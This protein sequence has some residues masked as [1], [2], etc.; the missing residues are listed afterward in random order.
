MLEHEGPA[1][2]G[3]DE[4]DPV[5]TGEHGSKVILAVLAVGFEDGLLAVVLFE[6]VG[7]NL[8][9]AVYDAPLE[10]AVLRY[11]N[12]WRYLAEV[13]RNAEQMAQYFVYVKQRVCEGEA[14]AGLEPA[15][16]GLEHVLAQQGSVAGGARNLEIHITEA[17]VGAEALPV[18]H[19]LLCEGKD[20]AVISEGL[21][22][23]N[24]GGCTKD[25]NAG[26]Q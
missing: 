12:H 6:H 2:V 5:C 17:L 20:E 26:G 8:Y 4:A 24:R 3:E 22:P 25:R 23:C 13:H 1:G 10:A 16:P 15:G 14:H 19:V 7:P 11:R 18:K 21:L 9:P